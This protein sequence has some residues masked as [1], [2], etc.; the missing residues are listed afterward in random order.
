MLD[1]NHYVMVLLEDVSGNVGVIPAK[2]CEGN[3]AARQLI[4][5]CAALGMPRI[6]ADQGQR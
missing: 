1:G 5:C 3:F 2:L 4:A 6:T